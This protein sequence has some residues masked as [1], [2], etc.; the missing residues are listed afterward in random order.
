MNPIRVLI[1]IQARSG[2]TRFP[3]KIFKII[4][5]K[6]CLDHVIFAANSAKTHL[7]KNMTYKIEC[8]VAVVYPDNDSAV[9]SVLL[10]R[11]DVLCFPG[12]EQDVLTRYHKA[13][14]IMNADFVVRLTSDCPL[15]LDYMI[16]KHVNTAIFQNYDYV[17]NV[18]EKC[19]MVADG[20]DCEVLSKKALN[21]LNKNAIDNGD[22]E[23]VTTYLRAFRP[24]NLSMAFVPMKIDTS[25]IKMSLDTEEDLER[26]RK[27]FHNRQFKLENAIKLYGRRC[28]HDL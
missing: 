25:E 7:V 22:R 20:Y 26:I 19:R 23:H 18:D 9:S 28:L 12:P 17:N 10:G 27:Y 3:G 24:S 8:E 21:W 4:G 16:S 14:Q 11:K 5:N 13:M 15:I 1:A 6:S 2:S